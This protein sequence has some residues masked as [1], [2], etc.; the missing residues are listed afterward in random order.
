M[1]KLTVVIILVML[2]ALAAANDARANDVDVYDVSLQNQQGTGAGT[3]VDIKFSVAQKNIFPDPNPDPIAPRGLDG[4][5][6]TATNPSGTNNGYY[7]RVWI[8]VKYWKVGGVTT[9]WDI[10]TAWGHATLNSGGSVG[11]YT[12]YDGTSGGVGIVSG[13]KGA[14]VKALRDQTVRW[15]IGTDIGAINTGDTYKVRVYAIEMVYIPTGPFW[16]GGYP[17]TYRYVKKISFPVDYN[18]VKINSERNG[19]ANL[20]VDFI[21]PNG[22]GT[23]TVAPSYPKGYNGFYI[24]KYELSQKQYVD[25]LNTLTRDQQVAHVRNFAAGTIALVSIGSTVAQRDRNGIIASVAPATN[26]ATFGCD[27]DDDDAINEANDGQNI[28]CGWL[29]WR[30]ICAYADWAALRPMTEFEYEKACKGGSPTDNTSNPTYAW[31]SE[32]PVNADYSIDTGTSGFAN[33]RVTSASYST[34]RGNVIYSPTAGI[35][36]GPI[37]CG[38]FAGGTSAL[39][40]PNR[41]ES[42]AS[43]YGVMEMTGNLGEFMIGAAAAATYTTFNGANGDGILSTSGYADHS[44]WEGYNNTYNDVRNDG[45]GSRGGSYGTTNAV[46]MRV[47]NRRYIDDPISSR[48]GGTG[49]RFVRTE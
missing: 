23:K 25:F 8:F 45:G 2:A 14:F 44:T 7:D 36:L 3:T 28:P 48:G 49:C 10:N 27:L 47:P 26:P 42:G 38:A 32:E 21:W 4:N 40:N 43:Y 17:D 15:N 16:L 29:E 11:A 37:R 6:I 5:T 20:L 19:E 35:I 39:A 46:Y 41:F 1:K 31:G 18:A 33:E 13:G 9:G 34:S 30:D 12:A 22:T 24:M